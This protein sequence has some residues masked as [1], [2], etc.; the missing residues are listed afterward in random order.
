M[1]LGEAV[2]S[3]EAAFA[4]LTRGEARLPDAISLAFP[5]EHGDVHVK[6]AHLKNAPY[7]AFKIA[8]G[9]YDNPRKGLSSAGGLML[10][11][12]ATTGF[13]VALLLD[14]GYLTSLRTGAAGAVAARYLSRSRLTKVAVIGAGTQGRFQV[15]AL[16]VVRDV[17]NVFVWDCVPTYAEHYHREMTQEL[18]VEVTVSP[19]I[20]AAVRGADLIV[21]V[22]P[23][24][25]PLVQA[26]WLSPG[27]HINAVG[28][29]EPE[30][31]ELDVSVLARADLIIADRLSQCLRFG[32]IHH[33]VQSGVIHAD[34][35]GGELGD[36]IAGHVRGR[37]DD[38]QIT[39][40]DLTGVGVQD[41]AIATLAYR[42]ALR[43]GLGEAVE[44]D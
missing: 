40:C 20:E 41:A 16:S 27:V 24:R 38:Q 12:D 9:F 22:T 23:S 21:T 8:S 13:P 25:Q 29:D 32:E 28:S 34:A 5:E 37:T 31:Q 1:T 30:K 33:A 18:G 19:S 14:N 17:P 35:V 7:F 11:F 4:A 42:N 15:R 39:V 10:V 3:I 43:M 2:D 36:V 44:S 6:G 26:D